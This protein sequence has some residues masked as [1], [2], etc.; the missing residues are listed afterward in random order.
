[1]RRHRC[2]VEVVA[3]PEPLQVSEPPDVL[4]NG[5]AVSARDLGAGDVPEVMGTHEV[6][7]PPWSPWSVGL[8]LA[9]RSS[10]RRGRS[11]S[12]ENTPPAAVIAAAASR[13]ICARCTIQPKSAAPP[14]QSQPT[15]RARSS[16]AATC[17]T[18][19]AVADPEET[20]GLSPT[21][22]TAHG[23]YLLAQPTRLLSA[24]PGRSHSPCARDTA[25]FLDWRDYRD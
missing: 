6:D 5:V 12:K 21:R 4:E 13:S 25:D 1:M 14:R 17:I 16:A 11:Q 2:E 20:A 22:C 3:D 8:G 7:R 23:R 9:S 10:P 24:R 18:K 15:A 19:S